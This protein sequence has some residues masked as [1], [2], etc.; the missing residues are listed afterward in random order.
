MN[1][2]N[3]YISLILNTSS[4]ASSEKEIVHQFIE[5]LKSKNYKL[6]IN[7]TKSLLHARSL[8]AESAVKFNCSMVMVAGGDGTIREVVHGL[9]GS[10]KPL[11]LL[12]SGT[13]NLLAN[14][15]GYK[16]SLKNWI[17]I[18]EA[19][20]LHPLDLCKANDSFF[21]SVGGVGFDADVV[22]I[23]DMQRQG[24]ITHLHYFFP[25]LKTFFAYKFPAITV[26]VD[27]RV[28]FS[29]RGIA[30]F[31]NISRYALGIPIL[32]AADFG[33]G[34]LD[35]CVYKC[36]NQIKLVFL[37]LLTILK[38]HRRSKSVIYKQCKKIKIS[39]DTFVRTELDGDPGPEMPLEI[40][41]IPHAVKVLVP[42]KGKPI[43][44]RRRMFRIFE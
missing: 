33:D 40:T 25:I 15:L 35:I 23:V 12:P 19:N 21:T 11:M 44:M 7:H 2:E 20:T 41:I 16:K 31:G 10:D 27:D 34:L 26:E 37:S 24:N 42:P 38:S 32:R 9:E 17:Q 1:S 30:L 43:G 6:Q 4:G 14:E 22:R 28:I 8:A 39:S 13:E 36:S 3:G 5:Y 29:D 18:F